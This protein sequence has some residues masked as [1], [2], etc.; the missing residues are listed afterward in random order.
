MSRAD[1]IWLF[2]AILTGIVSG[3]ALALILMAWL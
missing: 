1:L 3:L 2:W